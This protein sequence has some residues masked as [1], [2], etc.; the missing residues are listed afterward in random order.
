MGRNDTPGSRRFTSYVVLSLPFSSIPQADPPQRLCEI[1][2]MRK[3]DH[4]V[5]EPHARAYRGPVC[6]DCACIEAK[7]EGFIDCER[8][9]DKLTRQRISLRHSSLVYG[10]TLSPDPFRGWTHT[11]QSPSWY[12]ADERRAQQAHFPATCSAKY[13]R[14]RADG[15]RTLSQWMLRLQHA[16]RCAMPVVAIVSL[17]PSGAVIAQEGSGWYCMFRQVSKKSP[18]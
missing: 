3:R 2:M 17:P 14:L 7:D 6:E 9:Y 18:A 5:V 10:L 11:Q 8:L 15:R 1:G 13:R 16:Y 12:I 4:L